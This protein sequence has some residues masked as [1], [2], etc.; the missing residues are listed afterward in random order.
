MILKKIFIN[1]SKILLCLV[2]LS[3]LHK[4]T[5]AKENEYAHKSYLGS[6]LAAQ[7]AKYNNDNTIASDFYEFANQKNP[8]NV[9]ILNMSIMSFILAG[10]VDLAVEKLNTIRT[11]T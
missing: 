9:Q 7:I 5:L 6:L 10:R 2:F 4:V 3:L 1:K 8:K 11:Y